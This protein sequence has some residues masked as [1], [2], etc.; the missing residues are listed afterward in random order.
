MT[1]SRLLAG[2][3]KLTPYNSGSYVSRNPEHEVLAQQLP[4]LQSLE[5]S[6]LGERNLGAV[7]QPEQSET[8]GAQLPG[9]PDQADRVSGTDCAPQNSSS[10][11]L[12]PYHVELPRTTQTDHVSYYTE[13]SYRNGSYLAP[14]NQSYN[15]PRPTKR[16]R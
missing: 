8:A 9:H 7:I 4:V 5:W 12:P 14:A 3:P 6:C 15:Q 13:P 16:R 2:L 1:S 10:S 11:V